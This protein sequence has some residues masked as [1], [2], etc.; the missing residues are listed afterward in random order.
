M[1][2]HALSALVASAALLACNSEEP[3]G[4][5]CGDGV[6]DMR[7]AEQCDDGNDRD[8]DGCSAA[9]EREPYVCGDGVC[10]YGAG[11]PC[12]TCQRDCAD[13]D[14]CHPVC[15]D[16]VRQWQEECD[17]GS[18]TAACDADCTLAECGDGWVNG[19]SEQCEDGNTVGGDGCSARCRDEP[20]LS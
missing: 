8:G 14:F 3:V 17:Q 13:V 1:V 5:G 10:D 9:C 19:A 16:G 11:E 15:G 6:V 4:V 12:D 20:V 18:D 7:A 2:K